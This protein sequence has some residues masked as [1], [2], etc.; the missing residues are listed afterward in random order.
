MSA[1]VMAASKSIRKNKLWTAVA[2][3]SLVTLVGCDNV[4]NSPRET[5]EYGTNTIFSSFSGRSPKTL[6]PQASYSSDETLYT[7]NVYEPL[8][9]YHYLK[10][11]YE[12]APRTAESVVK[13][14]YL[15]KNGL[16]LPQDANSQDIAT[17][18]YR[19]RIKEGIVFAPHPAFAKDD[20]GEYRYHDLSESEVAKLTS[21]LE[22]PEKG[23]R[24][25]TAQDY[26]Y[27]VK[28]MA[29]LATVSPILGLM[30]EHIEGLGDFAREVKAYAQENKDAAWLDLRPLAFEGVKALDRYTLEIRVKG[31]YP[32]FD[33]WLAMAFF[34][35][36]PWEAEKFYAQK[37]FSE[38]NIS[39][40]TWPVGTGPYMLTVSQTNREHVLERNPNYRVDPYPC[41]GEAEDKAKGFLEDC[42]KPM[43]FVDKIV[44]TME[45]EAVPTTTKFLQGYY[46]SPQIT[47]LD[48]G[49]GFLV[50]AGDD[51][52][53]AK[54]YRDKNLQFPTAVEAN[55]WYIG[56]NWLDPIVGEGK[57]PEEKLRNKK[58]RQAISIAIDWEEQI[59]IF[60]KGQGSAAHGPLPP[61]LFGFDEKGRS[62]FNPVVYKKT[63]EGNVVRRSIDEAKELMRQAG[64]PDGRDAKTGQPLVLNFDWQGASPGSKAFLEWFKRQFAKID[65]Q[66]EIRATDYN[67]FQD[68]MMKGAAQIYYWGWLADYPDAE[69][70]LFLLYGPNSKVGTGGGGENASNYVNSDYD[71]LYDKMKYLENGPEK[72]ET[73]DKMIAIVQ[74]DAVWSF[75]YYPTSAAALHQW[76]KN[77]KPTSMIRNNVQFM[78][79]DYETRAAKIAEWNRPVVWPVVLILVLIAAGAVFVW[80]H[81]RAMAEVKGLNRD[82]GGAR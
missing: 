19:I 75:G 8:Y 61:G 57:T 59:A 7:Y 4:V 73:I 27:G 36:M 76:V 79:I 49:Q 24:E 60:E 6:D 72:A 28:R 11:P 29:S 20:K 26:V 47:R 33:N 21:P 62:A 58:L 65:I 37:G 50:A 23:T 81:M 74:D 55:L 5:A 54:L 15:D 30:T 13:P 42:G 12:L 43:P 67:R 31:K 22:L 71:R 3:L 9:T 10:R 34:A 45:K 69:N 14:V 78:R 56:F 38:N 39:L 70:F 18:V 63:P 68:K 41:E 32:Q 44:M 48:V 80:R 2:V 25:L 77:A 35:P 16:E 40:A 46:D 82:K 53:K 52:D 1:D 51:P 66:L 17:S 64:Y